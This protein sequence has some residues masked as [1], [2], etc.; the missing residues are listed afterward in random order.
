MA[1]GLRQYVNASIREQK[2]LSE[3]FWFLSDLECEGDIEGL[4]KLPISVFDHWLTEDEASTFLQNESDETKVER[5]R[6]L[7]DFSCS[8][9]D[10]YDCLTYRFK[11]RVKERVVFKRFLNKKAANKYV[12]QSP[13]E[14]S[15]RF[16]FR[17]VFPEISAVYF[18]GWD[19]TNYLYFSESK[20]IS[21]IRSLVKEKKVYSLDG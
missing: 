5:N 8:L 16:Q 17:I 3:K 7:H 15:S 21:E 1:N 18:E 11:G 2:E 10:K 14:C 6:A 12:E 9:L 20:Y 19:Y 4:V 13:T